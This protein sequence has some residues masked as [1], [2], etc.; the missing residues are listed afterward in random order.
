MVSS[1]MVPGSVGVESGSTVY[2]EMDHSNE[3]ENRRYKK[4][5]HDIKKILHSVSDSKKGETS[6]VRFL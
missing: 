4:W 3:G 5:V 1:L 2:R 6:F